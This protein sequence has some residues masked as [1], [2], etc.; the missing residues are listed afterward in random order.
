MMAAAEQVPP[1]TGCRAP[2]GEG[3]RGSSLDPIRENSPA[4]RAWCAHVTTVSKGPR[5]Y[6][7]A[8]RHPAPAGAGERVPLPTAAAGPGVGGRGAAGLLAQLGGGACRRLHRVKL[9]VSF[10][11]TGNKRVAGVVIHDVNWVFWLIV[12]WL[13]LSVLVAVV[14]G[15]VIRTRE[16]RESPLPLDGAESA[17]TQDPAIRTARIPGRGGCCCR[18]TSRSGPSTPIGGTRQ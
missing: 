2:D 12:G 9:R 3:P 8:V 16:E 5:R 18:A 7:R 6:R 11:P 4:R 14:F 17:N 13:V 10:L 15:R 1:P